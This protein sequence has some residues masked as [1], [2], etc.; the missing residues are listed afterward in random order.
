MQVLYRPT[1]NTECAARFR[2]SGPVSILM[3]CC[4]GRISATGFCSAHSYAVFNFVH[5]LQVADAGTL[6]GTGEATFL[7]G[8]LQNR[9]TAPGDAIPCQSMATGTLLGHSVVVVTTGTL[10]HPCGL[11]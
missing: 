7:L 9:F 10:L 2:A 8:L 4:L 6:S 3:V 1:A 11:L 5:G